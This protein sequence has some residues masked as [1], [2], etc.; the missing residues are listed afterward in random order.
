VQVSPNGEWIAS[1]GYDRVVRIWDAVTGTE[2]LEFP[3]PDKGSAISFNQDGTRIIAADESGHLSLWDISVLYARLGY[4]VF[5]DYVHEARLSPSG[6]YLI[7]NADDY[8][9][10]RIPAA[11]LSQIKDGTKGQVLIRTKSLTYKTAV[12]LDSKWVAAVEYDSTDSQSNKATLVSMD[13]RTLF[14]LPHGGEVTGIAFDKDSKFIAT[15]GINGLVSFWNLVTGDRLKLDLNNTEP[16]YSLALSPQGRFAAIGTKNETR[17][18][19]IDT[20]TL[21]AELAQPGDIILL[22][23]NTDGTLLATASSDRSVI[24][25]KLEGNSFRQV[26]NTLRFGGQPQILAFSPDGKWL[27]GGSSSGFA[28]IWDTTTMQEMARIA[29]GDPVTGI[30]FS[31]DGSQLFTVSRNMVQIWNFSAIPLVPRDLLIP[32]ACSHLTHNL[33]REDWASIFTGEEYHLLCPD[34]PEED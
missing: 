13:G 6:E 17:I 15:S 7:V 24:L 3:L 33:S 30:S 19:D 26:E 16:I 27:V 9:I 18:W 21:V 25:W 11:N 8:N 2:M 29:H 12:S 10:W 5:P 4:I 31:P 28:N 1:T 23:F 14:P 34:L 22:A 32:T 20:Y